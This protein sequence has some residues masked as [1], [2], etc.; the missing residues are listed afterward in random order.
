V[1]L[2]EQ[3]RS[4]VLPHYP[5]LAGAPIR[6]CGEGLINKTFLVEAANARFV[7]QR[8]S[9]IFPPVIHGN[10]QAV[11]ERLASR[12]LVTPRLVP[13]RDGA[14]CLEL[15]SIGESAIS[16]WR[17]MTHIEG[18]SFPAAVGTA[19][20]RAAGALL[21]RFHR[22]LEDLPHQF[23]GMR[24][25]VHDTAAH[26]AALSE[27]LAAGAA[28]RLFSQVEA[29]AT[30]I[31]VGERAMPPLTLLP[32]Q[33]CH[34]DPKFNNFL[35]A[36]PAAP[37]CGRA[38]CLVDLDTVGPSSRTY[39]MGDAWR[40]WCNRNGEDSPEASLDLGV[41][42]ASL[43]GYR[44]GLGR[45]LTAPE[46]SAFLHGAEWISLELAARFARDALLESYFGW[47]PARFAGR[48]E[49]NLVRARGQWSLHQALVASRSF[50]GRQLG[51]PAPV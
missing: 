38:V 12:G 8:V 39:E 7:L 45:T 9:A 19:Q 20:A 36:G 11:T 26:V 27:A 2:T 48:G 16:V 18:C 5:G 49:H 42:A 32:A 40:S 35:F 51:L 22:A 25:G 3:I 14:L 44:E 6:P 46:K 4:G 30:A 13:T 21:A 50:R 28:H 37:A 31:F 10:I 41:F 43:D 33:V 15:A 47:D 17:V 24:V 23:V 29:L 1:E 34:G